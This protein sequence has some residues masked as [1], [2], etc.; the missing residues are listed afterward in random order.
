MN[1]KR[2]YAVLLLI[3]SLMLSLIPILPTE[4]V[5]ADAS[6][7]PAPKPAPL[8]V[9][10]VLQ[11]NLQNIKIGAPDYDLADPNII[12]KMAKINSDA[13]NR[14]GNGTMRKDGSILWPDY[15]QTA[16]LNSNKN[17]NLTN[18]IRALALAY[19]TYG[20]D[21]YKNPDL[22][23]DILYGMNWIVDNIYYVGA[24]HYNNWFD[25]EIGIPTALQQAVL[26]LDRDEVPDALKAKVVAAVNYHCPNVDHFNPTW[27]KSVGSNRTWRS[28][29]RLMNGILDKDSGPVM[30][31]IVGLEDVF[32]RVRASEGFLED[33]SYVF[34]EAVAYTGGYSVNETTDAISILRVLS[35]TQFEITSNGV[36][37]FYELMF[38]AYEPLI[39]NGAIME[40]TLG[41]NV[42][43]P[44]N[45]GKGANTNI[46]NSAVQLSMSAPPDLAQ[47]I[48]S[49]AKQWIIDYGPDQ[50]L[51]NLTI[52]DLIM[53]KELLNDTNVIPRGDLTKTTVFP[54]MDR[55]VHMFPD[56]A[57]SLA[58]SS[59]RTYNYEFTGNENKRGFYYSDGMTYLYNKDDP[60]QY[61]NIWAAINPYRIPGTTV[62]TR[63]RLNQD[64]YNYRAPSYWAGGSEL[65]GTYGSAGME[66]RAYGSSLTAKKSW[67][68]F[69]NEIVALGA[70]IT[71]TDN[72]TIETTVENRKL[73]AGGDNALTVNGEA[74][75][76]V[77]GWNEAMTGVNRVNLAGTGGYY[78][79]NPVAI[80]GL[81]ESRTGNWIDVG[82]SSGT[83]TFNFMTLWLD[84]GVNPTDG[85]YQYA[86]LPNQTNA[87][88][89]AYAANPE[90][91]VLENSGEAQAVKEIGLNMIGANFWKNMTKTVDIITSNKKASV[92]TKETGYEFDIAVSDPTQMNEETI[93]IE[94]NKSARNVLS[95]DTGI[96]VTQLSPTIKLIIDVKD[97]GG[98][99]FKAKFTS[100]PNAVAGTPEA[101]PSPAP[102]GP[103]IL[104]YNG[105]TERS[106]GGKVGKN[107]INALRYRA[108]VDMKAEKMEFKV[109]TPVE[110]SHVKFAIYSY[111]EDKV[112]HIGELLGETYTGT[113]LPLGMN[114]L[115]FKTPVAIEAGQY[116]WLS[117]LADDN[118]FR[119]D[120][121][122][123]P[124]AMA[125]MDG[126]AF[127]S[128]WPA[129]MPVPTGYA[130][131][132]YYAYALERSSD[133]ML[134]DFAVNGTTISGF[135]SSVSEYTVIL[136]EGT[137]TPPVI[138]A[139]AN[140]SHAAVTLTQATTVAAKS[141]L[142]SSTDKATVTVTA[143]DGTTVRTY[144]VVF[145]EQNILET[146][147]TTDSAHALV[148]AGRDL[149]VSLKLTGG[150]SVTANVYAEDITIQYDPLVFDLLSLQPASPATV[151]AA[152]YQAVAGEVRILTITG[153]G[154]D[155]ASNLLNLTL[156]AKS[157]PISTSSP[158]R[159]VSALV[160]L[161]NSAVVEATP[162]ELLARIYNANLSGGS[163]SIDVGDLALLASH[164]RKTSGSPDWSTAGKAD[165]NGD[166]I[167][168][169]LDLALLA[170]EILK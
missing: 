12:S 22:L 79:P 86:I 164:Y 34:H 39:Y 96:T 54:G 130:N 138:T 168:D 63:V 41:R 44:N 38:D 14:W 2:N 68:M 128:N 36:H 131:I 126:I 89:D 135:D 53:N 102:A 119:I 19:N 74:K 24:E 72:R 16:T 46:I 120:A 77:L 153:D 151:V 56:Y 129:A 156:R 28:F 127:N 117:I 52:P 140:E 42:S 121:D 75:S 35:G 45:T 152:V 71:S 124:T 33:G 98:K 85:S 99:S 118:N 60:T 27:P 58:L 37:E 61:D 76:S 106:D 51:P 47:K 148:H 155:P 1:R 166:G 29:V 5:Y 150:A 111:A 170:A 149:H 103:S 160:G 169:I 70:G 88:T 81:R 158:V 137:Q 136:P 123:Q 59:A 50:Y 133:A 83:Q 122:L 112:G 30:E 165:L 95:K 67:F 143:E 90:F 104:G 101:V 65:L 167:V 11:V 109:F 141:A 113:N 32:K 82:T 157:L 13:Y 26:Y 23:N 80:N 125:Y 154:V 62:D 163:S 17:T 146:S 132:R 110:T 21:Y 9:Y 105:V 114:T 18:R 49:M 94:I 134:S 7:P 144:T 93:E 3:F 69:D 43:R 100:D 84:H 162:N 31:A 48:K 55:I 15:A 6:T 66:L 78:F 57:F 142:P 92:T 139:T 4:Q 10:D 97:S 115:Y 107:T 159:I 25:W 20:S 91:V 147:F 87:E 73:N 145:R 40:S 116:Y 108:S 8:D 161:S 64:G